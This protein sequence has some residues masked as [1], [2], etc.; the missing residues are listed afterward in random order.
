[1]ANGHNPLKLARNGKGILGDLIAR[2]VNQRKLRWTELD[3][4][5]Q[6]LVAG[7]TLDAL[8]DLH[9]NFDQTDFISNLDPFKKKS[10]AR[11]WINRGLKDPLRFYNG[12]DAFL[13]VSFYEFELTRQTEARYP[14]GFPSDTERV[15]LEEQVAQQIKDTY[16]N[17][18]RVP[19][20][21]KSLRKNVLVG[22]FVSFP[23]EAIRT[24]FN[25]WQIATQE[26]TNE[27]PA[28]RRIGWKRR[29]TL[30]SSVF[31]GTSLTMATQA[32]LG[33]DDETEDDIDSLLPP[34]D[35]NIGKMYTSIEDGK[36]RYK[37]VGYTF[38]HTILE[39]PFM[40]M[41]NKG[42]EG[43]LEA[44]TEATLQF[45][46]EFL[47]LE[48]TTQAALEVYSNQKK[49]GGEVY[50][51]VASTGTKVA[52]IFTHLSSYLV[53]GVIDLTVIRPIQ[54]GEDFDPATEAGQIITGL[55]EVELDVNK[56]FMFRAIDFSKN[57]TQA[58]R[59]ANRVIFDE[60]ASLG[61]KEAAIEEAQ[62]VYE[63][64]W[65]DMQSLY[66]SAFRLG[67]DPED[68][69]ASLENARVGKKLQA[70]LLNGNFRPLE[71]DLE[72]E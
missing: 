56:S 45:F 61:E 35:R 69:E 5:D 20:A 19:K 25:T 47:G 1:M 30:M 71:F 29:A 28:V 72:E 58:R 14:N 53:P 46:G 36:V 9:L 15:A 70:D 50:N 13:R 43:I 26:I 49:L 23:Y 41:L 33:I 7:E 52:D 64:M 62:R 66:D 3:L 12:I 57:R 21:I 65:N 17:Y 38:P 24:A 59:L 34:W 10:A 22:P 44:G 39:R 27:N 8:R 18:A 11:R 4:L 37:N 68:L 63:E 40:T 6:S 2:G 55:K 42:D 31:A 51:P 60:G 48:L 54:E 32:M 67:V 16:Q